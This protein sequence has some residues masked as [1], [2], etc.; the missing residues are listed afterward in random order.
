[1]LFALTDNIENLH[2]YF[3]SFQL[4]SPLLIPFGIRQLYRFPHLNT[5]I[6][7]SFYF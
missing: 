7:L 1:M 6:I 2:V 3:K 5:G 4:G